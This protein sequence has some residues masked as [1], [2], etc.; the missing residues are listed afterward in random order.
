MTTEL[1]PDPARSHERT[2][3][4]TESGNGPHGQ[5]I[6]TGR[7]VL[8][9]DEPESLGGGDTGP[10]PHTSPS[11]R[12]SWLRDG[13]RALIRIMAMACDAADG[14]ARRSLARG[15]RRRMR[16]DVR[17]R[18]R[19]EAGEALAKLLAGRVLTDPVVLALPRGGVSAAVPIARELGAPLDLVL[20]RKIGV[21]FQPELAAAAGVDGGEAEIVVNEDVVALAGL[22]MADVR[23]LAEP[24]LEEI[25]RRRRAYL[26][27]HAPVPIEGRDLVLVDD[28]IA[29]GASVRA[30]ITAL[31]RRHPSK[32]I[33]AVPVAPRET[34][35][36]LRPL[37]DDIVCL[38]SPEPFLAIGVHYVDFH[39]VTD[40]EVVGCLNSASQPNAQPGPSPAPA[41]ST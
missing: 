10:D 5:F 32:L 8:G 23:V 11:L 24:E 22:S 20:V 36:E 28:G 2:A 38:A 18:D 21:P 6:T 40:E 37:V 13:L 9:A 15:A 34:L 33:L 26:A 1:K 30:A 7:H 25:E 4:V 29:T 17:F 16:H 31:R 19:N 12:G 3:T 39:Q 35:D 27:G 14:G 41:G